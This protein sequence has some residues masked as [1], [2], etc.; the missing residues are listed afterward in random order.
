V[1]TSRIELLQRMPVFGALRADALEVLLA[2]ATERRVSAGACFFEKG[3]PA[4]SMFV[5]ESGRVAVVRRWQDL[6]IVLHHLGPGDCFG[7][8]ALMDL[9]PRSATVR[10]EQ[11][12]R[13]IEFGTDGLQALAELDLEQFALVQMNLGREICRRLR[14]A[15]DLLFDL[16]FGGGGG[17]QGRA[18]SGFE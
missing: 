15:D 9:M 3:D 8:M 4:Q 18:R 14:A 7:E 10:A 16:R 6:D 17:L 12:C 5:L 1:Q 11:D 13:A 2:R